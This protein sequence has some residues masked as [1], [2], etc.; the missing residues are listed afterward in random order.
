MHILFFTQTL[1]K[2]MKVIS[3]K[4]LHNSHLQITS[5]NLL[6]SKSES[7]HLSAY[8]KREPHVRVSTLLSIFRNSF[9]KVCQERCST[10]LKYWGSLK[11]GAMYI[12]SLPYVTV[13]NQA[14]RELV[15]ITPVK[16]YW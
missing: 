4:R 2:Q 1:K 8:K 7:D 11:L 6:N 3:L 15:V 13:E 9:R 10:F 14:E 5:S 12:T 16:P